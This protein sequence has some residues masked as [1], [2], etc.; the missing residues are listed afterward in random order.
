MSGFNFNIS[1]L[2][3][4]GT[5]YGQLKTRVGDK[6]SYDKTVA[7]SKYQIFDGMDFL[8]TGD[9][10]GKDFNCQSSINIQNPDRD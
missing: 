3:S 7:Y 5:T 1:T 4:S 6:N 10:C 9:T 2:A 8:R